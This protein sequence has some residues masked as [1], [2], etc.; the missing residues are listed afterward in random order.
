MPNAHS[1]RRFGSP[2]LAALL[3]AV[4]AAGCAGLPQFLKENDDKIVAIDVALQPDK[5]LV[6]RTRAPESH[7]TLVRRFVRASD[8][9][10]VAAAVANVMATTRLDQLNLRA[11]GYRSGNWNGVSGTAMVVD[12][13]PELLRLE[14]RIVDA[15]RMFA[16]N[17]EPAESFIV[18]PDGTRM[19]EATIDRVLAF[20]PE[21][22]GPNYRPHVMT[23]AMQGGSLESQP[24]E[25]FTFKPYS[26]LVYQLGQHGAPQRLLWTWSGEFGARRP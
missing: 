25:A 8:V 24:F 7:I 23:T 12:V 19:T 3:I 4:T 1:G 26:A 21:S 20:V 2:S 9:H 11:T 17:P 13:S 5:A 15:T 16:V 10:L 18:T 22:S 14:E 6:D